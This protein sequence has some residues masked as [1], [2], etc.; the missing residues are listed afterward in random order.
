MRTGSGAVLLVGF[1]IV[2]MLL[3]T[4]SALTP[5][6]IGMKQ[7]PSQDFADFASSVKE[8]VHS[9]NSL[10]GNHEEKSTYI[11]NSLLALSRQYLVKGINSTALFSISGG[12]GSEVWKITPHD[13]EKISE[14]EVDLSDI[15]VSPEYLEGNDVLM[16][17]YAL[18]SVDNSS[19][20][21]GFAS[22]D[23]NAE[24]F[25]QSPPGPEEGGQ[26]L[27]RSFCTIPDGACFFGSPWSWLQHPSPSA[28]LILN[29]NPVGL[30]A[31]MSYDGSGTIKSL[32]IRVFEFPGD[33]NLV[34]INVYKWNKTSG[35]VSFSLDPSVII[36]KKVINV[37]PIKIKIGHKYNVGV[38][39]VILKYGGSGGQIGSFHIV[40]NNM[41]PKD[42]PVYW[43]DPKACMEAINRGLKGL[44][45]IGGV[46]APKGG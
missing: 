31:L 33:D 41:M 6:S 40:G 23:K 22:N 2:V 26:V 43:N 28:F 12:W 1:A 9:Y 15:G 36:I 45:I 21:V 44:R 39:T 7:D 11:I 27:L 13:S 10:R 8:I 34:D 25:M 14:D 16:V 32:M 5:P 3:S 46:P 42:V 35:T 38:A 24:Q 37:G 17:W 20:F 19:Y 4:A 18:A 30:D 29:P